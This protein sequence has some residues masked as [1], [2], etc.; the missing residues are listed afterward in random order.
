MNG[1]SPEFDWYSEHEKK[2]CLV[3]GNQAAIAVHLNLRDE[4]VIRQQDQYD[5]EDHQIHVT[6]Y[7][8]LKLVTEMLAVADIHAK[9]VLTEEAA[10]AELLMLPKP[11]PLSG[12]ER[13]RRYRD[14]HCNEMSDA[15]RHEGD[16]PSLQVAHTDEHDE[17]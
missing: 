8:V 12:A 10:Q 15:E 9:I 7:N 11:L 17:P 1:N 16:E 5:D 2:D 13:Q 14:K 6:K 4:V 3:I